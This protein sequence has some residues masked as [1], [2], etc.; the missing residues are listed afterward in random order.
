MGERRTIGA[1]MEM[2]PEKLAF[3]KGVDNARGATAA[4]SKPSKQSEE[5]T[6]EVDVSPAEATS[7]SETKPRASRRTN[8]RTGTEM[9]AASEMLDQ[10]LVPVTIRVPRRTAQALRRA[11]LEQRLRQAKP[12]TQQQIAEE[13]LEDWLMRNGYLN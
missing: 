1:A 4:P 13:A 9:P 6:I 5:K 3:I 11:Y 8:R 10:V 7:L 2:T 12:D